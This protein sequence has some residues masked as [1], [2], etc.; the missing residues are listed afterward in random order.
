MTDCWVV[1][2]VSRISTV[3]RNPSH[4][5][6]PTTLITTMTVL[7]IRK[8][9]SPEGQQLSL[10]NSVCSPGMETTLTSSSRFSLQK[11]NLLHS[12]SLLRYL[13]YLDSGRKVSALLLGNGESAFEF[14]LTNLRPHVP[15]RAAITVTITVS[16]PP[17]RSTV[18]AHLLYSAD[19]FI[20]ASLPCVD[21]SC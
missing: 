19:P 16:P 12:L 10:T 5:N 4:T 15:R 11:R 9:G 7:A 13:V 20:S 2:S 1:A 17:H 21:N 6:P 18:N 3:S 8:G 14:G